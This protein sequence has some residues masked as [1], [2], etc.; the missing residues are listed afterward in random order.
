VLLLLSLMLFPQTNNYT[1]VLAIVPVLVL[2]ASVGRQRRYWIAVLVV[3][4]SPWAFHLVGAR[5][6][7]SL[8]Q[9]LIPLTLGILL[10]ARWLAYQRD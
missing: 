2:L 3:L 5:W 8:E 10:T 1:L 4:S 9:L 6:H 7:R